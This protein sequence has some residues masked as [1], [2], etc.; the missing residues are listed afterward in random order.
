MTTQ[1]TLQLPTFVTQTASSKPSAPDTKQ[2][3]TDDFAALFAA[4]WLAPTMPQNP[5]SGID[6]AP[7]N[8][9]NLLASLSQ[10]RHQVID[11][12]PENPS[13]AEAATPSVL[14][15]SV[16][17]PAQPLNAATVLSQV[18]SNA[19]TVLSQVASA[20]TPVLPQVTSTT[21]LEANITP[22]ALATSEQAETSQDIT[23]ASS[24]ALDA[25]PLVQSKPQLSSPTVEKSA[26]EAGK[27]GL[28][29]KPLEIDL[30]ESGTTNALEL[31]AVRRGSVFVASTL[32]EATRRVRTTLNASSIKSL[33][34]ERA[35][36][37]SE[38]D[39]RQLPP[40]TL[41]KMTSSETGSPSLIAD[42]VSVPRTNGST[43]DS[44]G[45]HPIIGQTINPI[46][47]LAEGVAR[48]EARTLRI[49][50][51]PEEL[52]HLDVQITRDAQG[53]LSAHLSAELEATRQTLANSIGQLREAL[54][55]A[56]ITI[57][58]LNV[59]TGSSSSTSSGGDT[60]EPR[61]Q[62]LG[63]FTDTKSH[64]PENV[65]ADSTHAVQEDKFLS[66]RA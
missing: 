54:E 33:L 42:A 53:R 9:S 4:S 7:E 56:G 19:A 40:S 18:T 36:G 5:A 29:G 23:L 62:Q 55:R 58:H 65:I 25:T 66:F 16:T 11:A 59:N 47:A 38:T 43:T 17:P 14:L 52:G 46:V 50:L 51:N 34:N 32:A 20:T 2:E 26:S 28:P 21:K 10:Q 35:I 63:R 48:R 8:P 60:H 15:P 64:S 12:A 39:A 3:Q 44:A 45:A 24:E 57:D 1:V 30:E 6:A 61:S 37:S 31:E 41:A 49:R 27:K 22:P 13:N